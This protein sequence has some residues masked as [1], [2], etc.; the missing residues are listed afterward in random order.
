[1][2]VETVYSEYQEAGDIY[3]PF[4]IGVK[5]AGQLAQ[6]INI[7]NIAVNSEIDD[8]IF[9]MPKPVVETEDEEDEDEDDGGNK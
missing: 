9:V 6:S 4:N 1:M 3:F 7:E 5:Y 2:K 8:A